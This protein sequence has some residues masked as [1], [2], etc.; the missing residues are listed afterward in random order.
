MMSEAEIQKFRERMID[1]A[2]KNGTNA[3]LY[4]YYLGAAEALKAVLNGGN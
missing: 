2:K 4:N 1:Q 3:S